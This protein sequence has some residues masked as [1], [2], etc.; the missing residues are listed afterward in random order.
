MSDSSAVHRN[1]T[2]L[3]LEEG[4]F[5][6]AT[7]IEQLGECIDRHKSEAK[8]ARLKRTHD[9]AKDASTLKGVVDQINEQLRPLGLMIAR[10][11][12][13][14]SGEYELYYG[15]VNLNEEDGFAKQGW[16][17][18]SEQE[19][20]HKLVEEILDSDDKQI[21]AVAATKC[22]PSPW[23]CLVTESN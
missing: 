1:V 16:L 5:S 9:E 23:P 3:L 10:M 2:Q 12:S 11:K 8:R 7:L 14:I 13:R 17:N 4:I 21:E 15:I 22:A 6:E 19:F 20:F 18:K